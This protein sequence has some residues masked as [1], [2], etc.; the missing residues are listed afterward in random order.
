[1]NSD[2]KVINNTSSMRLK[3]KSPLNKYKHIRQRKAANYHQTKKKKGNF[4]LEK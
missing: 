4:L 1:M 3:D 2:N